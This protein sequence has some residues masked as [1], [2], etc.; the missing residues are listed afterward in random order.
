MTSMMSRYLQSDLNRL[1]GIL[2]ATTPHLWPFAEFEGISVMEMGSTTGV[3]QPSETSGAAESLE[4][5]FSPLLLSCGL[6]SY[7][8][9][10]SGDH[11]LAGANNND[12]SF[13][14]DTAF[15][16]GAWIQP[17]TAND[18]TIMAVYDAS[19]A[20]EW[21]WQLAPTTGAL[22]L[23]LYDA[24]ANASVIGD[25]DRPATAGNSN[26]TWTATVGQWVLAITTYDGTETDPLI[27]HYINGTQRG[28]GGIDESGTYD[29]MENTA[30]PLLIGASELTA[31]PAEEFHGRMAMPFLTG[32]ELTPTNVNDW[33]TTTQRMVLGKPDH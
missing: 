27:R 7:F 5:D 33:W 32:K 13:E 29:E 3:L 30:T 6:N 2:G 17:Y 20:E 12:F 10:P 26:P 19:A 11:H 15:S 31:A 8:F 16:V 21:K 9:S 22:R 28:D 1:M 24:S 23:E 14:G 18:N 4:D 25:S